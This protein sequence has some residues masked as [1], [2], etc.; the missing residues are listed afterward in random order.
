MK[1]TN[2]IAHEIIDSRGL[3]TIAC[4]LFLENGIWVK[5]S[6]PN[7]ISCGENEAQN[8]L[9]GGLRYHG[10]GMRTAAKLINTTIKTAI[11]GQTANVDLV[12]QI[13]LNLDNTPNKSIIGANSMLGVSIATCRA[14]A[15]TENKEPHQLLAELL[16]IDMHKNK[17]RLCLNVINGGMHVA[18]GMHIQEI[19]LIPSNDLS[20]AT[21]LEHGMTIFYALQKKFLAKKIFFGFGTEGGISA[22]ISPDQALELVY[23]TIN[24]QLPEVKQ[25]IS[26]GLDIAASHLFDRTKKTYLWNQSEHSA[27]ELFE[28][29]KSI[30]NQYPIAFIEDPFD[31]QDADWWQQLRDTFSNQCLIVGDDLYATDA[32]RISSSLLDKCASGVII[33]PNQRGTITETLNAI[34]A[35]YAGKKVVIASHRS[36]ETNDSFIADLAIGAGALYIKAGCLGG[37]RMAKYNRLVEIKKT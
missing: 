35:S 6:I 22:A 14:Q 5:A 19:M 2:L 18:T 7:G 34:R 15:L 8:L 3:P 30:I 29:Y 27:K 9:D 31:E 32:Y 28:W 20:I 11:V 21:Q 13:L 1:I 4:H 23:Q 16:A 33:K 10:L 26:I 37:E 12:D 25:G 17:I 36:R 24:E